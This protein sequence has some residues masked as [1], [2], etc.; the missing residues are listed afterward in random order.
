MNDVR[1]ISQRGVM[2]LELALSMGVGNSQCLLQGYE[3]KSETVTISM[4]L[5]R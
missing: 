5:I 1:N 2:I 4:E 3:W